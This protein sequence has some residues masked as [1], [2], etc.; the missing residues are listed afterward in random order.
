MPPVTLLKRESLMTIREFEPASASTSY[1]EPP[2]APLFN[3]S[4]LART[5]RPPMTPVSRLL[6]WVF[7]GLVLAAAMLAA[8]YWGYRQMQPRPLFAP[9][10]A[11][12]ERAAFPPASAGGAS[13]RRD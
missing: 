9:S 12:A 13:G 4:V 7:V 10:R 6:T 11:S 1:D 5:S 3:N 8:G 2:T